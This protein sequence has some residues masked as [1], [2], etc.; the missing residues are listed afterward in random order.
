M[1]TAKNSVLTTEQWKAI[2]ENDENF[3]DQFFYAVRTTKIFCRPS[4][5]SRVPNFNNVTIFYNVDE[6]LAAGF[7]PCKRCKSAGF[8]LPDEEWV[9]QAE[10]YMREHSSEQLTL[11]SVAEG[12][13]GSPY[14]L[15]RVFKQVN[16]ITPLEYIHRIRMEKA[17]FYLRRTDKSIREICTLIGVPNASYFATM[18]KKGTGQTPRKFRKS[19]E[20]EVLRH[21]I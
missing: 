3:D 10:A 8:R 17:I 5:K 20:N 18:F 13:H 21:E 1:V 2:R 14:H 19:D 9:L 15:H 12:C 11:D 16:G 4:C 6:A 7:R